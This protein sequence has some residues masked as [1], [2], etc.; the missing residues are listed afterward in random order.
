MKDKIQSSIMSI[1]VQLK[2]NVIAITSLMVAL[3][4][5][6][7]NIYHMEQKERNSNLR[8]ASFQLLLELSELEE[9]TFHLQYDNKL[10]TINPRS[11]WVKVRLISAVS[12]LMPEMIQQNTKNLHQAWSENWQKLGDQDD[13]S[14]D[15]VI[16]QISSVRGSLL[17]LIESLQ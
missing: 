15:I 6:S 11:G 7:A 3:I 13:T 16:E 10:S 14:S 5:L 4:G 17:T 12:S 2:Q 1:K 8:E 9:I